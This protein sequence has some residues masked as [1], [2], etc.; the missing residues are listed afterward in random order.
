M[1][2]VHVADHYRPITDEILKAGDGIT[3]PDER[4]LALLGARGTSVAPR[5]RFRSVADALA[6][7]FRAV[8][9]WLET[10]ESRTALHHRCIALAASHWVSA[11][12]LTPVSPPRNASTVTPN[13]D[14]YTNTG[15]LE[16]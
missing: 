1:R 11:R 14:A 16:E 4:V 2:Y 12:T 10:S 3:N 13:L 8:S 6:R 15:T 9:W 5:G 7:P